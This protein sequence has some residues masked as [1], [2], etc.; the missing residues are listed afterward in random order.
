MDKKK[1][2]KSKGKTSLRP[3]I[4]IIIIVVGLFVISYTSVYLM[5]GIIGK[6]QPGL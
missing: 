4:Y 2:K 3:L 5:A 6:G 1:K